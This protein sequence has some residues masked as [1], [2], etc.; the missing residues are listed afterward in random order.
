MNVGVNVIERR[1]GRKKKNVVENR[2]VGNYVESN[3]LERKRARGR[4][5]REGFWSAEIYSAHRISAG[6][7]VQRFISG[8][9]METSGRCWPDQ[10]FRQREQRVGRQQI[11]PKRS[12]RAFSSPPIALLPTNHIPSRFSCRRTNLIASPRVT[13][14][15][16][17]S[18][19]AKIPNAVKHRA[20]NIPWRFSNIFP[21]RKLVKRPNETTFRARVEFYTIYPYFSLDRCLRF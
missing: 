11:A 4:E 13:G 2:R 1:G 7:R 3:G 17:A 14:N 6:T 9:Q 18:V 19:V 8:K 15:T 16:F 10:T 12:N 20:A 5:K 21:R